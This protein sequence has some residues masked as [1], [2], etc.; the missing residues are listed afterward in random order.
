MFMISAFMGFI[1]TIILGFHIFGCTPQKKWIHT[2][3]F[4][5]LSAIPESLQM[6]AC[7]R[8]HVSIVFS[9]FLVF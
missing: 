4:K 2:H 5:C 6:F 1:G 3:L 9:V 7:M 8:V